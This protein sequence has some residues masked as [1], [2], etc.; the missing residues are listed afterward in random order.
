MSERIRQSVNNSKGSGRQPYQ[1]AWMAHW[2][3]PSRSESIDKRN[4]HSALR[5]E[6]LD[7]ASPR[8]V[9]GLGVTELKPF[10]TVNDSI[11]ISPKTLENVGF[12]NSAFKSGQDSDEMHVLNPVF[13]HN[14]AANGTSFKGCHSVGEG[15]SMNPLDWMKTH[16][17]EIDRSLVAA[18]PL[19]ETFVESSSR[20]VP[21]KFDFKKHELDKG[22][23]AVTISDNQLPIANLG[24]LEHE[25]H[26]NNSH[27]VDLARM[28]KM[29]DQ[30]Q[31]DNSMSAGFRDINSSLLFDTP[32]TSDHSLPQFGQEW[33]QKM[34]TCSS[35]G[36]FPSQCLDLEKN[37]SKKS[38][39][40]Y[41]SPQKFHDVETMRMCTTVEGMRGGGPRVS[42]TTHSLLITK[43]TDANISKENDIFRSTRV[44]TKITGNTSEDLH[45]LSPFFGKSNQGLKLQ[46]LSSSDDSER[47]END[48]DVKASKVTLKNESS[49]ETDI[50]DMDFFN[51]K[52]PVFGT[53]STSSI[54]SL[55]ME[56]NLPPRVAANSSREVGHR[57]LHDINLEPP[58]LP[59]EAN[60]SENVGFSSSRTQSLEMDMLVANAQPNFNLNLDDSIISDP[61]NRWVKRLKL[62][63]SK[64]ANLAQ[65]SSHEKMSKFFSTILKNRISS[66]NPCQMLSTKS[67]DFPVDAIEKGKNLMLSKAWIQ[68]WM[69]KNSRKKA[70]SL[71]VY[72]PQS[73]KL[74]MEEIEKKQFPSIAAMALMGKAM[75]GFQQCELQKRGSITVWNTK[76]F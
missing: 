46:S 45:S 34:Q 19:Q 5:I 56:L 55:N 52:N 39:Y 50:L 31:S 43:K 23:A 66:P 76:G 3:Q 63:S 18:K 22:K 4:S 7:Y 65:N 53:N 36:L 57:W 61:S 12:R 28:R 10:K 16:P 54:K 20:I 6:E 21:Y 42:Q 8:S 67:G 49:A 30:S 60:L 25:P 11:R 71:V 58:A 51:E 1:S 64:S 32:S 35:I 69:S 74:A 48:G 27:L 33:F 41:Y 73:S 2:T 17:L 14:L 15:T 38:N 75:G 44:I 59:T 40:G 62:S 70:E 24:L 29:A 26:L 37:K 72:E 13:G 68:R 47:K 9:K